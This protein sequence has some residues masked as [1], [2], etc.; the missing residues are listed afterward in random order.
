MRAFLEFLEETI[1]SGQVTKAQL[2][3]ARAPF[4]LSAWWHLQEPEGW[5]A[6]YLSGR[7]VFQRED[8]YQP[9]SDAVQD[10]LAF[11]DRFLSLANEL[12]LRSWELEHLCSRLDA[13]EPPV[14][15]D[16]TE[17]AGEQGEQAAE[18]DALTHTHVQ[19]VLAKLGR[20]LGCRV[21][22]APNDHSKVWE[23]QALAT[24]SIDAL[25]P[26]GM[27]RASERII[28]LIDVI[29]L[30]GNNQ[31]VAA[32]EV[33]HSALIYSGLLRLADLTAL[34]PSLNFPLYIVAPEARLGKVK[35]ELSR[36]SFQELELHRRC[37][38]FS[39]E[40][41]IE[42]ADDIMRWAS[43]ASVIDRLASKVSDAED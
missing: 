36:P 19:A 40:A 23:G 8:L 32:F 35:Q 16:E 41:L 18:D 9:N 43:D 21:W 38:F 4:F 29:W 11:R 20:K 6:Y 28:R 33:E 42:E 14:P 15:S 24:F 34:S 31:I 25:P 7:R 26:L 2:Q 27:G 17:E 10:Y 5:P 3:P 22:I 30:R 12:K 39:A 1:A 13:E 37:G